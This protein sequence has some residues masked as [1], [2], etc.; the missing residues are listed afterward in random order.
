MK[1][2]GPDEGL[3]ALQHPD[4]RA[5]EERKR[6]SLGQ[7]AEIKTLKGKLTERLSE[8]ELAVIRDAAS[9][10]D[11]LWDFQAALGQHDE[12]GGAEYERLGFAPKLRKI[13]G[14]D[15]S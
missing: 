3:N 1:E 15:D 6:L 14:E 9:V 5:C 7:L 13:I 11:G 8:E 4:C 2:L 12:R 10:L